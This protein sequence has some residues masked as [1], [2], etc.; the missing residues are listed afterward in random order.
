MGVAAGGGE[1]L[2]AEGLLHEVGRGAAVKGMR[3]V[4]VPEPVRRDVF[5][6][7][8]V[9]RSLSDDPPQLAAA[10]RPIGLLRAKHRIAWRPEARTHFLVA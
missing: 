10:K 8:G 9:A 1:A 7:A 6:D 2:V 5:F 3:G 4:R